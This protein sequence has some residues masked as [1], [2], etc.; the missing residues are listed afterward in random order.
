MNVFI[1][2]VYKTG[3]NK[4]ILRKSFLEIDDVKEYVELQLACWMGESCY[5]LKIE[6]V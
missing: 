6:F 1:V 2:S 3:E 5:E 4:P